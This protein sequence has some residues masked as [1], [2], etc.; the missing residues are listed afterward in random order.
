VP[1]RAE[2]AWG[3]E[4]GVEPDDV[5]AGLL[6]HGDKHRADVAVVTSDE[7]AQGNLLS[8]LGNAKLR[9]RNAEAGEGL[10]KPMSQRPRSGAVRRRGT[11][12]DVPPEQSPR[13]VREAVHP[14]EPEALQ[15]RG[16]ARLLARKEAER[17]PHADEPGLGQLGPQQA[18]E[19]LLLRK[20][21][22]HQDQGRARAPQGR[23]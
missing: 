7:Y 2:G 15:Q 5:V 10:A 6:E 11:L 9:E 23:L 14:L 1:V 4:V 16:R 20:P 22:T 21:Q 12:N 19:P 3:E 17:N 8:A 18:D 13:L